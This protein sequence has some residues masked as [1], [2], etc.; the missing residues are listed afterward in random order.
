MK[1]LKLFVALMLVSVFVQAQKSKVQ[2]AWNHMKYQE[3]DKAQV[4]IDEAALNEQTSGS[5]KTWVYRGQIY[6][7]ILKDAKFAPKYPNAAEEALKSYKKA[8][9]LDPKNEWA[10]DI[11]IDRAS[12]LN[13]IF[14]KALVDYKAKNY[15]DAL[16]GFEIVSNNDV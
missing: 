6:S 5:A 11:S 7:G 1:C 10:Q 4:A 15:A 9:E 13:A 8:M 3:W 16:I 2:T 12:I 14:N